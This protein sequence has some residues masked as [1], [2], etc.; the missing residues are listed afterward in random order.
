M[1]VGQH[2]CLQVGVLVL[3]PII[4]R[5]DMS[6]GA[7]LGCSHQGVSLPCVTDQEIELPPG[8]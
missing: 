3:G 6:R 4:I 5:E 8:L 2:A 7:L 1:G